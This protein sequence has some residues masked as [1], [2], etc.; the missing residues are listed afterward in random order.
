MDSTRHDALRIELE[1]PFDFSSL[2]PK[3]RLDPPM[4][5]SAS[6]IRSVVDAFHLVP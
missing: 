2:Q 5:A 6:D 4:R 1:H 3:L